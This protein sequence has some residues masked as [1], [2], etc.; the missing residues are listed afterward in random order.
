MKFCIKEQDE[1]LAAKFVGC[2]TV[3][4]WLCEM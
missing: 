3:Q 2:R 4:L 1:A